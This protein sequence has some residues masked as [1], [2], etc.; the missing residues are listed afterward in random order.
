MRVATRIKES[1][2]K[3]KL[4]YG[5]VKGYG[6][7]YQYGY[8]HSTLQ[9]NRLLKWLRKREPLEKVQY[10]ENKEDVFLFIGDKNKDSTMRCAVFGDIDEGNVKKHNCKFF[11]ARELKNAHLK[12]VHD[13]IFRINKVFPIPFKPLWD[14]LY[15]TYGINAEKDKNMFVIFMVGPYYEETYSQPLLLNKISQLCRETYCEKIM[16][17]VDPIGKYPLLPDWFPYFDRIVTYSKKDAEIYDINYIDS[18]CVKFDKKM[19]NVDK[20]IH[21]RCIDAGRGEFIKGCYQWL[22]DNGV[23]CDFHIQSNKYCYQLDGF[24]YTQNRRS[25]KET[26]SE[27]CAAN[28]LLEVLIPG[29]NSGPT[30]RYKEAIMYGKKLLTNNPDAKQLPFYDPDNILVFDDIKQVDC[31]WIR[32]KKKVKYNYN[33]EFSVDMFCEKIRSLQYT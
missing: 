25:Y 29:V 26:V 12:K 18:P 15:S 4:I 6:A 32:E 10:N 27:E 17:L 24:E 9:T 23:C 22:S 30:L 11:T 3:N 20:D 13:L 19:E 16:Y 31:S 7:S 14:R 2:K 21:I 33:G 1:L 8:I 28:V 5:L